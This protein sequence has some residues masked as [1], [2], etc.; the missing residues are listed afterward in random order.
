MGLFPF[1]KRLGELIHC[2]LHLTADDFWDQEIVLNSASHK[3]LAFV[4]YEYLY[5]WVD[6]LR[7]CCSDAEK[8]SEICQM[9]SAEII[10]F[11]SHET[12]KVRV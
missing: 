8:K 9:W 1:K 7:T 3:S 5:S 10:I 11:W 12:F 6:T 2:I 4:T